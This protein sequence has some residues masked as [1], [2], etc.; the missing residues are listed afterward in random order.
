MSLLQL[1]WIFFVLATFWCHVIMIFYWTDAW[2][3]RIYLLLWVK[4]NLDI[5]STVILKYCFK[6]GIFSC[7]KL[8][9]PRKIAPEEYFVLGDGEEAHW[10]VREL[11]S[12]S[13]FPT[14]LLIIA[15]SLGSF[16]CTVVDC[17]LSYFHWTSFL[18]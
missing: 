5:D 17:F 6:D 16:K 7:F 9:A 10:E 13:L 14:L 15:S 2:Q 1:V 3:H 4:I 11:F 18:I 12:L 8:S